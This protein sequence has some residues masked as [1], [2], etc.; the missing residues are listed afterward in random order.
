V[1]NINPYNGSP[2]WKVAQAM[3]DT[4][5]GMGG[6]V[7]VADPSA[8][9]KAGAQGLNMG[10]MLKQAG[11]APFNGGLNG[12]MGGNSPG[13]DPSAVA[14]SGPKFGGGGLFGG[15]FGGG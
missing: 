4:G 6:N 1:N 8:M 14:K 7:N 10:S 2:S 5:A 15:L 12:L 13:V 9:Y 3:M 11:A